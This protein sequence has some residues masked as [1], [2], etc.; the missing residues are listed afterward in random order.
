[1]FVFKKEITKNVCREE[2]SKRPKLKDRVY[3]G[4]NSKT[5]RHCGLLVNL[6]Y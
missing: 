3:I 5:D 6:L 2:N 4:A 1:M